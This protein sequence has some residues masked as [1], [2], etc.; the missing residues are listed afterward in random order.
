MRQCGQSGGG[1]CRVSAHRVALE[2][3]ASAEGGLARRALVGR[4]AAVVHEADV[5]LEV[6]PLRE[7]HRTLCARE[8]TGAV[9]DAADVV[10]HVP[11]EAEAGAALF[12]LK[13]LLPLVHSRAVRL[14]VRLGAEARPAGRALERLLTRARCRARSRARWGR[15]HRRCDTTVGARFAVHQ[16]GDRHPGARRGWHRGE[17]A[18]ARRQG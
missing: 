13:R 15:R 14:Q 1:E 5:A 9:V 8:W 16:L 11:L 3:R 18:P 4:R 10:V 7:R 2:L 17:V 6:V 12:A